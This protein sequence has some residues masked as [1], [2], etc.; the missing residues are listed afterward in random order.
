MDAIAD[1]NYGDLKK[2]AFNR[3][4]RTDK[5]VH[6]L[7]NVFSCKIHMHK[8]QTEEDFRAKL[9]AILPNDMKVFCIVRCS[10]RFNAKNCTSNREYSYYLPS[11]MLTKMSDLFFGNGKDQKEGKS[12][13]LKVPGST[14]DNNTATEE[15]KEP[16]KSSGIKIM[17]PSEDR[18]P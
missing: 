14:D 16:P 3:A 7:Q 12:G 6:A 17:A 13:P 1:Y 8:E 15:V 5:R 9:N 4:T 2:I 11:F 10:S 18:E